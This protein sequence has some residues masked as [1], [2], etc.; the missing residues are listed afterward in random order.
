LAAFEAERDS[1]LFV[2]TDTVAPLLI[3]PEAL[4]TVSGRDTKIGWRK[5][6]MKHVE[7]P[8][9]Q[10]PKNPRKASRDSIILPI[11]DLLCGRIVERSNH[12]EMIHGSRVTGTFG[13]S[14]N[15]MRLA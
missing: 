5:S 11:E 1:E 2:H 12:V 13:V 3:A 6:G 14:P 4:E 8:P 10:R 7:L 9:D 15:L